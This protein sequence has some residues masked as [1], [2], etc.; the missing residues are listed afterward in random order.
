MTD[1]K[2]KKVS[3]RFYE[4]LNDFLSPEKKKIRFEHSFIDR[5]AVKDLIESFGV[6][7]TEIDLILV[8]GKSV[9]FDYI[10]N[11][12]DDI[13]VYPVF[14]SFDISDVQHLRAGPLRDP[15]FICDDHLGKLAKN[16]RMIGIDTTYKK[17]IPDSAIVEIS[18]RERRVILTRDLGLL[19]I[20]TVTHGYYIR[21]T[22]PAKQAG[23]VI[24]KFQLDKSLKYFSR[25]LQCNSLLKSI[26][27]DRI[28]E[29]IPEKVK[30]SQSEFFICSNCDKIYWKGTHYNNM[31]IKIESLIKS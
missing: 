6:P 18:L 8:N 9:T 3:I 2:Y 13:S 27:K 23:E 14:E 19:K 5:T 22:N 10:I 26:E 4:E 12:K 7:H 20:K 21:N 30:A 17:D 29:R 24:A 31:L 11:D 1:V 16:L 15:K 28:V 25:C